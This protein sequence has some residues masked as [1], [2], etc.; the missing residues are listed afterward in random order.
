MV[1]REYLLKDQEREIPKSHG[2]RRK[3]PA[4]KKMGDGTWWEKKRQTVQGGGAGAPWC[5][6]KRS[7]T[8][9]E[10]P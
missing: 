6:L 2:M 1:Y 3:P 5:P 4:K 8:D 7:F 10:N 9:H